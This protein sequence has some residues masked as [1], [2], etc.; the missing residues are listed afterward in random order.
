MA[1]APK[2][3]Q[4]PKMAQA[5][6]LWNK[7]YDLNKAVEKFTVGKDY[8]L[9]KALVK[10]D[11]IASKAH[12]KMLT[13]IGVLTTEELNQLLTGL[14]E[15]IKLNDEGKFEIK[16]SDEDCH[17]AIEH[18]LVKNFGDAGK[19][20]HTARSRNDQV[21]TAMRLFQKDELKVVNELILSLK[22]ELENNIQKNGTISLPGYTH[23]QKA[24]PMSV[25]IWLGSFLEAL[26]DNLKQVKSTYKLIDQSPLGS[27]AGFGVP[28]L[29]LDKEMTAKEMGFSKVQ[30][31]PLYCQLSRGKFD[32]QIMHLLTQIMF[33]VNKLA[34]DVLIFTMD[35]FSFMK[36]PN[37]FCSGSSIMPQ[38]K[39]LDLLE[40]L[41]A[42]YH[43]VLADEFKIKSLSGNLMSGYNRDMQ[44]TKEPTMNS[45]DIVKQSLQMI[46]L[47]V[48]G[49]EFNKEICEKAMTSELYATEEAYKLVKKGMPFRDAYK[50]VGKKFL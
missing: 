41:R 27:A 40:L 12:A 8:I 21:L 44:L 9:D 37:E 1:Q 50:E 4:V 38:K 3:A 33:D 24:M 32:A 15:I 49:L 34:T 25:K 14:D 18:Y 2:M 23:M 47:I 11:C 36:I 5:E 20:I 43:V 26:K 39:N 22:D 30:E 7:G 45:L 28:V 10:Y 48:K 16:L 35:E 31:N 46:T 29:E 13:K 42:K 19:K 17:T 6:K